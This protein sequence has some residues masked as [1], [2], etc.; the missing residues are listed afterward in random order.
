MTAKTKT[1]AAAAAAKAEPIVA[2]GTVAVALPPKPTRAGGGKA[3]YPFADLEVGGYFAVKNKTRREM[4]GPLANANKRYR[5]VLKNEAGQVVNTVQ[6][7]EFYAAD[8]DATTAAA[9]KGTDL[10]GA[11][12]LLIRSK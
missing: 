1:P 5:T 9:F 2:L 10:E 12:V 11:T 8:V 7:R 4:A 3:K 6:E